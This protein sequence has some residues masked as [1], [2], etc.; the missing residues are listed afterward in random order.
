MAAG[1]HVIVAEI[2]DTDESRDVGLMHRTSLDAN[3]GM[4]FVFPEAHRHCMWMHDTT[5]PLSAAFLD[6]KGVVVNIDDMKPMTDDYHCAARP[7]RF[8]LE[9][10]GGW[11][12]Q[13]GISRGANISGLGEA[14]PTDRP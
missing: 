8:V 7:V 4:L 13:K 1:I 12:S 5:I 10:N 9:M 3:Q 6:D 11:F 2:A 14:N